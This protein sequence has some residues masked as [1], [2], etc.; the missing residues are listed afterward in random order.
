MFHL[1]SCLK[2]DGIFVREFP[3]HSRIDTLDGSRGGDVTLSKS[4]CVSFQQRFILK[5]N[6]LSGSGSRLNEKIWSKVKQTAS[7]R[8][9]LPYNGRKI[10]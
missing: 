2:Y 10:Y 3:S 6:M 9:Y 8:S 5:V 4:I 7:H 1:C